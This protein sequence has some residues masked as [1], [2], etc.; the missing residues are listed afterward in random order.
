MDRFISGF[1]LSIGGSNKRGFNESYSNQERMSNQLIV[2]IMNALRINYQ[3][4]KNNY[5]G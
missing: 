2:Q 4:T 1:S 3:S 5:F